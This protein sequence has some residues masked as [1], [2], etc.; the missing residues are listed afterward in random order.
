MGFSAHG[1]SEGQG[2]RRQLGAAAIHSEYSTLISRQ[3]IRMS[4]TRKPPQWRTSGSL[5]RP[6]RSRS[7]QQA[8]TQ[9]CSKL[10]CRG[11][12][13]DNR[14]H[15]FPPQWNCA[16]LISLQ[17]VVRKKDK[18]VVPSIFV[19][20]LLMTPHSKRCHAWSS[21]SLENRGQILR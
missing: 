4:A 19:R 21:N 14:L 7:H 8:G 18:D 16:D 6:P 9:G 5:S 1:R 12:N 2:L 13:R 10:G 11:F 15:D 17:P 3:V 20:D